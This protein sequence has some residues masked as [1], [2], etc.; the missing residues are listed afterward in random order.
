MGTFGG[1]F[2]NHQYLI[3][4]CAP[5]YPN[6]DSDP[7]HP[8][9]ATLDTDPNGKFLP[10]LTVAASTP[11]S[12]LDGA[13]SFVLSGNI[14]PKDYFGDGIFRAVNTMM[15]P[16]Q[17]SANPPAAGDSNLFAD[18]LK[19]N[20]LPPQTQATIADRLDAKGVSWKWYAGA[21]AATTAIRHG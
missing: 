1:S 20:T 15:P 8:T 5:E 9:I 18:R 10:R 2:L 7:A 11:A 4:A 14:T 12:A 17:P 3:C 16:Y 6:A 21:W 19:P 13:P